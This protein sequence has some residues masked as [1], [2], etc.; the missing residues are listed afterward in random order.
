MLDNAGIG[1]KGF[2]MRRMPIRGRAAAVAIAVAGLLLQ[3]AGAASAQDLPQAWVPSP[4]LPSTFVPRWDAA[5][6]PFPPANEVVLFGGSPAK[7]GDGWRADTWILS[8]ATGSWSKGIAAP[9]G[10]TPRG[11]AAAAYDPRS[12]RVVMFGGAGPNQWPPTNETW[13]FDGTGWTKGPAAPSGLTG[14]T[15]ARM[16]YDDALG[17]IVLFGGSGAGI[18]RGT[19]LYDGLAG[20]WT[21]GPAAP[22]AMAGR[23]FFGM[24][25]DPAIRKVVVAGGDGASD[26][27]FFDG[28][29]WTPG[30]P[31][32]SE[33]GTRERVS[34][35]YDPQLGGDVLFG[36]L[37]PGS[38]N[39]QLF[40]LKGGTWSALAMHPN[41]RPKARLD[42][43]LVWNPTQGA[44]SVFAGVQ[45]GVN[46][47]VGLADSWRL[48]APPVTLEPSSGPVGTRVAIVSGPGWKPGSSVKLSFAKK[49]VGTAKA[50]V[51]GTVSATIV[52]PASSTGAKSVVLSEDSLGLSETAT[53]TVTSSAPTGTGGSPAMAEAR[54]RARASEAP[55]PERPGSAHHA[56]VATAASGQVT[57]HDGQFWLGSKPILLHGLDASPLVPDLLSSDYATMASWHMNFIRMWVR[58]S[59]LEPDPPTK[60]GQGWVHH[61]DLGMLDRL[62]QQIGFAASQG[63]YV[64]VENYCGP[65]CYGNGWPAWL[66]QATYNSHGKNYTN[67]DD[68]NT[69]YWTDSLQRGFTASY[70]SWLA[71]Q[72]APVPGVV[73]YEVMNEPQAGAYPADHTTTQMMLGVQAT[74]A[75]AVR[76]ADPPRVIF[77]TTRASS[78][79]GLP[80]ANLSAFTALGNVGFDV[81]DYFGGRWGGGLRLDRSSPDWG[82]TLQDLFIFTITP[83][84]PPYLGTTYG[85]VRFV[86]TYL[87]VLQP[88]GIPLVIGEFGG[89]GEDE[90]NVM[91]LFGT[92]A[93]AFNIQRVAWTAQSYNTN[94]QTDVWTSAG[95]PEP[96]VSILSAAAAYR[97]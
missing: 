23:V 92:M 12:R 9:V 51:A 62:K 4:S 71:K 66:Y 48:V 37:G 52:V 87:D 13:L 54:R 77:F 43:G 30:P 21:K 96:W 46:G 2:R 47:T 90:P 20:T 10:L 64:M 22:A 7:S 31:M 39:N 70:L 44:F 26:V 5:T 42:P 17:R 24:T 69:D 57:A 79:V 33:M 1:R 84:L 45:N 11:G 16:A 91:T 89:K 94:A 76:A 63:L 50:S 29:K 25:Y 38:A 36:G 34:L 40:L 14:R 15:G 67:K 81:H 85:Q 75:R 97:G 59:E 8:G 53:F 68:A 56:S 86:Q 95:K 74:L 65:P 41:P 6:A 72:L 55:G 93:G 83:G 28:S 88:E 78:G 58:W 82:E 73:G 3:W 19:W 61:Y 60:N 27:W 18:P 80:Q 32:T 49:S 35:T